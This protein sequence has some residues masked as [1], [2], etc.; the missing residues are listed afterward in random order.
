MT[1]D[2]SIPATWS[3]KEGPG[4]GYNDEIITVSHPRKTE[5]GP[6]PQRGDHSVQDDGHPVVIMEAGIDEEGCPAH[7]EMRGIIGPAKD[8]E[9]AKK[10]VSRHLSDDEEITEKGISGLQ[11]G[12]CGEVDYFA[13]DVLSPTS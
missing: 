5:Y 2:E 6:H 1:A 13:V 8:W 4:T 7:Y 3:I 10:K 9:E 11:P 12:G